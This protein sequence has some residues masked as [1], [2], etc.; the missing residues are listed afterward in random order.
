ML[1][2]VDEALPL[3]LIL[4]SS[5]GSSEL[6]HFLTKIK[7]KTKMAT[8]KLFFFVKEKTCKVSNRF[9]FKNKMNRFQPQPYMKIIF[10]I[11]TVKSVVRIL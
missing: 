9:Y 6:F 10:Q 3:F 11:I 2:A 7:L 4:V 1:C 5:H 8:A